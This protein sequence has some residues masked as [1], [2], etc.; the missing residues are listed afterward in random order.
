[1]PA[2]SRVR[3]ASRT[4]FPLD[5]SF[6]L[7]RSRGRRRQSGE[8]EKRERE[9][10]A[11]KKACGIRRGGGRQSTIE[12][13]DDLSSFEED[14]APVGPVSHLSL[15]LFLPRQKEETEKRCAE[16]APRRS[17]GSR[18]RR[19][20]PCCLPY[21]GVDG[22]LGCL[23]GVHRQLAPVL[24]LDRPEPPPVVGLGAARGREAREGFLDLAHDLFGGERKRGER[25]KKSAAKN[26]IKYR[27]S[28]RE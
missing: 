13:C 11:S 17:S 24:L 27:N 22:G 5:R 6:D 26:A 25:E 2:G 20:R 1:M 3:D 23:F 14:T 12:S 8:R 19:R 4:S 16:S 15:S 21:L 10:G 9:S 28:E 18:T 7:A